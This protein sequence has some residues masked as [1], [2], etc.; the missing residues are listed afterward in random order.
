MAQR[1]YDKDIVQHYSQVAR[2]SGLSSSATMADD[3]IRATET[4]AIIEFVTSAMKADTSRHKHGGKYAL[5]DVGCGNGHTL[6]E[7]AD[8]FPGVDLTGIEYNSE[9]RALAEQRLASAGIAAV[10]AG[11]IRDLGFHG[12]REFDLLICQRVIINLLDVKDQK[13][14]L[15][16]IIRAVRPG[17]ALLFIEAFKSGLAQVNAAR[18]E[19]GLA[20]IPPAIHN[21]YLDDDFFADGELLPFK[22]EG[23]TFAANHLS[24]H[25]FVTRVLNPL[26]LG[27][28]PFRRNSPFGRFFSAALPP[29]I[30]D[31]D[32][33]RILAFQRRP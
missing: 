5:V 12:D 32:Q 16:N 33:L 17:G 26:L 6:G 1:P 19:F 22:A 31:F 4:K 3:A 21:L 25:Y 2:D 10:R 11:D 20:P 23:W 18:D 15:H 29:A 24:T 27:D 9:L 13:T 8:A 28:R 7:I 30:G 14:A